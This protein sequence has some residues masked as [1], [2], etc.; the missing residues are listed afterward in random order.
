MAAKETEELVEQAKSQDT[1]GSTRFT[2][3]DRTITVRWRC[4]R[5]LDEEAV[6][7]AFARFG[8]IQH[9]IVKAAIRTNQEA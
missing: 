8:K 5:A 6:R 2:E 9:C 7:A 3:L 1:E 4:E